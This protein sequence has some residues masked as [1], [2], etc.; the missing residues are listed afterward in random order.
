MRARV[1]TDFPRRFAR[2]KNV[3]LGDEA[4]PARLQRARAAGPE[5]I[6]KL[7]GVDSPEAAAKLRFKTVRVRLSDAVAL[8]PGAYYHY[9][10]I[11]LNAVTAE[12]VA[13]GQVTDILATGSNDVYVVVGEAGEY[14][15]PA[16]ADVVSQ[17]D[18]EGRRLVVRLMEGLD[19]RPLAP[20]APRTARP[21]K[22]ERV[23]L[24]APRGAGA[25]ADAGAAVPDAT[26]T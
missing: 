21:R 18:L 2:L 5:I 23:D 19:P 16:V 15:I 10:I 14:L 4:T 22:A 11:G 7:A 1:L 9:Q 6:L 13:L 24:K 26:S 25:G 20:K 12:G 3:Y 8:P 17:V